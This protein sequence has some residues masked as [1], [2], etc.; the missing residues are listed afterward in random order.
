MSDAVEPKPP[1]WP[2]DYS[3]VSKPLTKLS[4]SVVESKPPPWPPDDSHVSNLPTK[5]PDDGVEPKPPPWPP[6][7]E[8]FEAEAKPTTKPLD[9]PPVVYSTEVAP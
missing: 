2:P 1:S 9:D 8:A 3:H 5:L 7:E 6:D 4:D